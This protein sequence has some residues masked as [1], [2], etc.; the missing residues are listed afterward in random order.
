MAATTDEK[1]YVSSEMQMQDRVSLREEYEFSVLMA[2]VV[3]GLLKVIQ[4]ELK[5]LGLSPI[6]LGVMY[7]VKTSKEPP[8]GSEI[9]RRLLRR[10]QSV[11]QVLGR[12]ENQGLVRLIRSTK[13]KREVPVEL[14]ER[15][16]E[17]FIEAGKKHVIPEILASLSPDERKQVRAILEKLRT[18]TYEKLAPQPSFP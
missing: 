11:H 5:P 14:T 15:G 18:A 10:P 9:A 16:E 4:N 8:I 2:Q 13:G 12:M 3:E 17:A 7:A 6:Q 1:A